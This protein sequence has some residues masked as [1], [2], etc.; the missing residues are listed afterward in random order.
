MKPDTCKRGHSEWRFQSGGRRYCGPCN[1]LRQRVSARAY[2]WI[3]PL[4]PCETDAARWTRFC[5][6][7]DDRIR[8][9]RR[10]DDLDR[11][12]ATRRGAA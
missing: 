12:A 9:V 3:S 4:P 7:I 8:A 6:T 2:S 5:R 10:L 1:R 11:A